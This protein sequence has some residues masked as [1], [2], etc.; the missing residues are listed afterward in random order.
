MDKDAFLGELIACW[1]DHYC[2]DIDGCDFQDLMLKHGLASE[3]PATKEDCEQEWAQE[4]DYNPGDL[5]IRYRP[6]I[7]ALTKAYW[8]QFRRTPLTKTQ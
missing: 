5:M 4:F 2:G 6:E 7:N 1:R 3:E 8:A